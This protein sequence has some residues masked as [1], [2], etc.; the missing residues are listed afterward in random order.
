MHAIGL[1][2]CY[3][4]L[5]ADYLTGIFGMICMG[6]V[7]LM[8]VTCFW[9]SSFAIIHPAKQASIKLLQSNAVKRPSCT[10]YKAVLLSKQFSS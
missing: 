6:E 4:V 5:L 7:M 1:L 2:V 3:L 9:V 8:I 10:C